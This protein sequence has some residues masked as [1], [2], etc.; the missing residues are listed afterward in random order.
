MRSKKLILG[1]LALVLVVCFSSV[2]MYAADDNDNGITDLTLGSSV[3]KS[4]ISP[5]SYSSASISVSSATVT[6]RVTGT[7]AGSAKDDIYKINWGDGTSRAELNSAN[8]ASKTHTYSSNG[9]YTVSLTIETWKDGADKLAT[10]SDSVS[11]TIN[12]YSSTT[13]YTVTYNLNGGHVVS[14]ISTSRTVSSGTTITL[15]GMGDVEKDDSYLIGWGLNSVG[16][17]Q[18]STLSKYTVR[19]NVTFYALWS[20]ESGSVWNFA[21]GGSFVDSPDFDTDLYRIVGDQGSY[22]TLLTASDVKRDG[23]YLKE[24]NTSKDGT[25]TSY[26]VSDRYL[27]SG[28]SSS[29]FAI[30]GIPVVTFDLEEVIDQIDT[31]SGVVILTDNSA[32]VHAGVKIQLPELSGTIISN[33]WVQVVNGWRDQSGNSYDKEYTVAAAASVTLSPVFTNYFKID[34]SDPV[35]TVVFN[36]SWSSYQGHKVEWGDGHSNLVDNITSPNLTHEYLVNSSYSVT[37]SSSYL[38]K[39]VRA[40]YNIQISNAANDVAAYTVTFETFEGSRILSQTIVAGNTASKPADP[41]KVGYTF[42]GWYADDQFTKLY[43]FESVIDSNII[44]YAKWND[45][46]TFTI[47]FETNGGSE[48]GIKYV[49]N[50]TKISKPKDPTKDGYSFAGW[51]VNE[52]CTVEFDFNTLISENLTLYAKWTEG[53]SGGS[54]GSNAFTWIAVILVIAALLYYLF[55]RDSK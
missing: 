47:I 35:A 42:G 37:V 25:G 38:D 17:T 46:G 11:V 48:V 20:A 40:T 1:A 13:N 41:V 32:E 51:Y 53:A 52:G 16:G 30:W 43:D 55:G 9:T 29:L 5:T 7:D 4:S 54:G 27:I 36:Q 10:T 2:A 50:N 23:Y 14:G 6:I 33:G 39:T 22:V 12:S 8:N 19:S 24:W 44:I 31:A 49:E 18:Y 34:L 21:N 45:K 28:S 26:A 3:S 15:P